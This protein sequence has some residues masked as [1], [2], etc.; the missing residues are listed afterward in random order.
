MC[1][2]KYNDLTSDVWSERCLNKR[3]K[4][5]FNIVTSGQFHTLAMF[6]LLLLALPHL[7]LVE[8]ATCQ[9]DDCP[10]GDFYLEQHN[11]GSNTQAQFLISSKK[12]L[13][14]F[15][16]Q[17][18]SSAE[19]TESSAEDTDELRQALKHSQLPNRPTAPSLLFINVTSHLSH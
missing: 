8:T 14:L 3:Q 1:L 2:L 17:D 12:S 6:L 11:H 15:Q 9:G 4:E 10:T 16:R 7:Q 5:R 18:W 19:D 13:F